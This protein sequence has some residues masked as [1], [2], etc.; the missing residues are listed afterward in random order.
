M[1]EPTISELETRLN[2]LER[3]NR[4]LKWGLALNGIV[5]IV[6][7]IF[8]GI[9]TTSHSGTAM[10]RV[11]E[12]ER[13]LIKDSAGKVRAILG[14]E[15]DADSPEPRYG[16]FIYSKD[17]ESQSALTRDRKSVV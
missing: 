10:T 9:F 11:I 15:E 2:H 17:G 7:L 5:W 4:W 12:A 8:F 13:L 16:I 6:G 3:D 14:Q 1:A